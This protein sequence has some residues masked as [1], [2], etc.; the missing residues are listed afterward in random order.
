MLT[1]CLSTTCQNLEV[2]GNSWTHANFIKLSNSSNFFATSPQLYLTNNS[3][4][5]IGSYGLDIQTL[6]GTNNLSWGIF[7]GFQIKKWPE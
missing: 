3:S 4:D 1:L 5:M 6:V 2:S 7:D